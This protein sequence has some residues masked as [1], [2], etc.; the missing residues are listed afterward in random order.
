MNFCYGF[1]AFKF[2]KIC[3]LRYLNQACFVYIMP[4]YRFSFR[5]EVK[6]YICFSVNFSFS[7]F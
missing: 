2:A 4:Y 1:A 3:T 5:Y 7:M 6:K